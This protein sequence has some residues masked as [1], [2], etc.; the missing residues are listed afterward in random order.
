MSKGTVA[1]QLPCKLQGLSRAARQ[2][3]EISVRT[4]SPRRYGVIPQGLEVYRLGAARGVACWPHPPNRTCTV[5]TAPY[6]GARFSLQRE[7]H[8][9]KHSPPLARRAK[10]QRTNNPIIHLCCEAAEEEGRV[11][12]RGGGGA[13]LLLLLPSLIDSASTKGGGIDRKKE[14]K[15]VESVK[16][17]SAL[18]ESLYVLSDILQDA[19]DI[20]IEAKHYLEHKDESAPNGAYA[21][22]LR[23]DAP[24]ERVPLHIIKA[25]RDYAE[26]VQLNASNDTDTPQ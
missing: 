1:D 11:Q 9:P 26:E 2:A 21:Y 24:P 3:A 7:N 5:D 20:I 4:T 12:G 15:R 10:E 8:T 18:R 23:P 25:A 16:S 22:I 13:A 19:L 14:E 6:G 17:P